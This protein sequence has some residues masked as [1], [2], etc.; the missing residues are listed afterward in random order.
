M[1]CHD[2]RRDL[3]GPRPSASALSSIQ[4]FDALHFIRHPS[5]NGPSLSA[6]NTLVCLS[7]TQRLEVGMHLRCPSSQINLSQGSFQRSQHPLPLDISTAIGFANPSIP[8]S[9][10]VYPTD[11]CTSPWR[12]VSLT[13]SLLTIRSDTYTEFWMH[14]CRPTASLAQR[15][16]NRGWPMPPKPSPPNHSDEEEL[17]TGFIGGS[18]KGQRGRCWLS[19]LF[20]PDS[21]CPFLLC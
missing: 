3:N 2:R 8:S 10:S 7:S 17:P 4:L 13:N 12:R 16:A 19:H 21:L 14:D 1:S 11:A 18:C 15:A 5:L 9:S 20:L 6:R